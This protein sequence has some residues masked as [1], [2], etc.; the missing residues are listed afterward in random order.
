LCTSPPAI[1][2]G[3]LDRR[4]IPRGARWPTL[5]RRWLPNSERPT[6]N[7]VTTPSLQSLRLVLKRVFKKY[8]LEL[9]APGIA[10]P[11]EAFAASEAYL[12][13]LLS[14]L[15]PV[16][17]L[18]RLDDETTHLAGE[19]EQDLRR[20]LRKRGSEANYD[21]IEDRLRE[22]FEHALGK[23]DATLTESG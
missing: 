22:C 2:R 18:R 21:D 23:L 15:G 20:H 9:M 13:A 5:A 10:D 6:W 1:G 19:A 14:Q 11:T 3:A 8:Y 17:F 4:H 7:R 16:E 12:G